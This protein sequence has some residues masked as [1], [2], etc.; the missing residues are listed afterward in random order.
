[1][2]FRPVVCSESAQHHMN[3]AHVDHRSTRLRFPFLV[4]AIAP[5][6][7]VPRG[8]TFHHP[9]FLQ[10]REPC[11]SFR[12]RLD[13]DS[14]R[15]AMF[16]HPCVKR[17]MVIRVVG[18]YRF[19]TGNIFRLDQ[20]EQFWCCHTIIQPCT[21]DQYDP[22]Q[23]QGIHQQRSLAPFD[24][25]AALIAS[26]ATAHRRRLDRLAVD[27]RGTGRG[28][29][30]RVPAGRCA[31]GIQQRDPR[32]VVAPSRKVIVHGALGQQIVRKHLPLTPAP[33][34][35][36]DRMHDFAQ[37]H[38]TRASPVWGVGL[39]NQRCQNCPLGVRQ[40]RGIRL[41]G[42]LFRRPVCALL[43]QSG[44]RQLSNK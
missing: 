33:I 32:T 20:L 23:A 6:A 34:Q 17:M 36:Q 26:L 7:T 37:V 3:V 2:E 22:P 27:A 21:R 24:L 1:M 41:A 16:S 4:F 39:G 43:Y 38:L 42:R 14:P 28:L 9:T 11:D 12:T 13:L 29:P 8:G 44:V 19:E 5:I 35:R 40:I 25:L 10:W 30:T 18:N 31:Q 15:G